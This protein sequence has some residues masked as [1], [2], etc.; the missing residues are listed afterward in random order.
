M[1][2]PE[3]PYAIQRLALEDWKEWLPILLHLCALMRDWS[4]NKP[5]PLLLTCL[6]AL[7]LY[8]EWDVNVLEEAVACFYTQNF[9]N[10][11]VMQL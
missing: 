6:E 4:G 7:S 11:L 3:L 1:F 5:T 9:F 10:Y 8:K 2:I